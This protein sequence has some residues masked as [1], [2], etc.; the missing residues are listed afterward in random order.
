VIKRTLRQLIAHPLAPKVLMWGGRARAAG[1]SLRS[2]GPYLDLERGDRVLRVRASHA[3]Y[4]PHMID[5]FD[6]YTNSVIPMKDGG[7]Q[8][9]DMSGPRYHKLI[10]FGDIPFL[11]PSH[12]EPFETT[13]EYL[14]FADLKEG[15]IV[16]DIGAYSGVTSI[17]FAQL[18]GPTGHVYAFEA[19]ENNYS[20]AKV[21]IEMTAQVMGLTNITLFHKAIW[22]H[23]NGVLFSHEG[24]MGSSAVAITGGGRGKETSV[25]STTLESFASEA[26]LRHVDF[27]KV[28][29]EGGETELLKNSG[30][31]LRRLDTKVII[32]PHRVKGKLNTEECCN[33]LK[34]SG[35]AVHVRGEA[36]G[37]EALIEAAPA[38]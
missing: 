35:F 7:K 1:L 34:S 36:G 5:S 37:S 14:E 31:A 29:I 15:Q 22:S 12:T 2:R 28:D 16:M 17:I 24:T 32:E 13:R 3:I 9:V 21:N 4:L 18:V 8:I 10:G 20:C 33:L 6:Y 19:D 23:N 38:H 11:F 26:G 27:V 30:N 25:P